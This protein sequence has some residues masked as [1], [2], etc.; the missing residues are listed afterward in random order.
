MPAVSK[1]VLQKRAIRILG[2]SALI[3]KFWKRVERMMG[4][5]RNGI[6]YGMESFKARVK[7]VYKSHRRVSDS[8]QR[9]VV[10]KTVVGDSS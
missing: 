4:A 6:A 9:V 8:Q 2:S 3:W 7:T 1:R 10:G 5:C